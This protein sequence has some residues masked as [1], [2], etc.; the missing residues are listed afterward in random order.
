MYG[1]PS[2][3]VFIPGV[4][5]AAPLG[6]NDSVAFVEPGAVGNNGEAMAA[7]GWS[8]LPVDSRRLGLKSTYGSLIMFSIF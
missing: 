5:G 4:S 3:N 7:P 1:V 2:G 6:F 8:E